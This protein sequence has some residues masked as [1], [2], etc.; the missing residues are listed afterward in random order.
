MKRQRACSSVA[1]ALSAVAAVCAVAADDAAPA[2]KPGSER[3]YEGIYKGYR[4]DFIDRDARR[5]EARGR[6]EPLKL[7]YQKRFFNMAVVDE[8]ARVDAYIKYALKREGDGEYRDAI[9]AYRKVIDEYP[10]VLYRVAEQGIFVQARRYCQQRILSFP[11]KEL[12]FYRAMFDA[13]ARDAFERARRRYSLLDLREVADSMMATSYGAPAL[14]DLGNAALDIGQFEEAL[15]YYEQVRDEFRDAYTVATDSGTPRIDGAELRLKIAYCRKALFLS[16]SPGGPASG[17][18]AHGGAPSSPVQGR[19]TA[20][21]RKALQAATDRVQ[22]ARPS[23]PAQQATPPFES[24]ADFT[25]S[26]PTDDPLNLKPAVWQVALPASHRDWSVLFYPVATKDSLIYRHRNIVYCR[27]LLS[28]GLRWQN[29]VGGRVVWENQDDCFYPSEEVL[30][31][32]GLVFTNM[33]KG[34]ASL[35][36]LE[37]VTGRLRWAHGPIAPVTE[38]D[39]RTSYFACP[40]GGRRM[41]YAT[42]VVDN[43]E[44]ETHLDTVYGVRAFDSATGKVIWS[45]ELCRLAVGKFMLSELTRIRNRIRSYAT[46]PVLHAGVLFC[47]TDAGVV[48]A[49]DAGTGAVKWLTRYPYLREIH[50]R[51]QPLRFIRYNYL[52]PLNFGEHA[53]PLWYNQQRPLVDG[54]RMYV[55]PVD[56]DYIFCFERRTGKIIWSRRKG[57]MRNR[58]GNWMNGREAYMVGLVPA[59]LAGGGD[60]GVRHPDAR[61]S[62]AVLPRGAAPEKHYLVV[63]YTG[64]RESVHLLDADTGLPVWTGKGLFDSFASPAHPIENLG[65]AHDT[66]QARPFM[67]AD[68]ILYIPRLN[69]INH[70]SMRYGVYTPNRSLYWVVDLK[71]RSLVQR[72]L[73]YDG[74]YMSLADKH[75]LYAQRDYADIMKN[76]PDRKPEPHWTNVVLRYKDEEMPVNEHPPFLPFS[77]MTFQRHGV[78]FELFVEPRV[79]AM[80][81][82][83][84]ALEATLGKPSD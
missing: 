64:P 40:A 70:G 71:T 38:E 55:L 81:Y 52:P 61:M 22:V 11:P 45:R 16:S 50:D 44:G 63:V 17:N 43:I 25:L 21:Q 53:E 56:A 7:S 73:Y 35:V 79:M 42:Y 48:A 12:A 24:V 62:D 9:T 1:C 19:L 29:D 68:G 46:P 51:T 15:G 67:T 72:R 18:G 4:P 28:G 6:D 20:D 3:G 32:D 26:P 23:F 74:Q 54:D 59:H 14:F 69:R 49:L 47:V 80:K 8:D 78:Q 34:G 57:G 60:N 5:W 13:P 2:A 39:V 36:A 82:D 75:I 83:R 41:I 30:V 66:V 65:P 76:F 84:A 33:Y 37:E 77:R 58:H 27:S 10:H 31:Q